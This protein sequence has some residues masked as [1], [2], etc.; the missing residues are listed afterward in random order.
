M[1]LI[2]NGQSREVAGE[3]LPVSGLLHALELGEM[4][5]LVELNGMAVLSREFDTQPVR[6]GDTIEI[7]RM[8]AGG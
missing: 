8:V 7:I 4:P 2:I 1:N 3:R 5:V 6:E